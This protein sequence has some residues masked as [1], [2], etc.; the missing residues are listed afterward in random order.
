VSGK[1]RHRVTTA[2]LTALTLSLVSCGH[3]QPTAPGPSSQAP[4]QAVE[5]CTLSSKL[6][7]SCGALW[8]ITTNTP[9]MAALDAAERASG[10]RFDFVYR[11]HDINDVVPSSDDQQVVSDG[12]ILHLSIDARDYADKKTISWAD[13]ASGVYDDDL[14]RQ[15][16]GVAAL[17][18]PFFITF[19]HEADQ[20]AKLAQGSGTNFVRA[21]RH[22]H[23]LFGEAGATNAV[24]VWVMMGTPPALPR[25]LELWPGNDYV[26]W[27]SWDVYNPSGCRAGQI[28]AAK[29]VSFEQ[30]MKIFFDWVHAVGPK[31]GVDPNKPMMISEAGSVVYPDDVAKTAQWYAEIPSVLQRYPQIK[32]IGLWDHT[33]QRICDYRFTG[34]STLEH[35][36]AEAGKAQWVNPRERAS[37]PR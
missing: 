20:P 28:D 6:V 14:R 26:D 3:T 35:A 32:A 9:T 17:K 21:W 12:R 31:I 29:Y 4:T 16:L 10:R 15:A 1:P 24:W 13:I 36:I 5:R 33:G 23:D 18:T 11:F 7:P 22:V 19:D 27:I 8:G 30:S 25:V 34:N 2:L 37:T